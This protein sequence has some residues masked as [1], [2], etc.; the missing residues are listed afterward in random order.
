MPSYS[1]QALDHE[2]DHTNPNHRFAMV[3][4]N[5]VVPT[6]PTRVHKPA[7]GSFDYPALGQ[8]LET[9]DVVTASHDLQSELSEWTELLDPLDQGPKIAAIGPDDLHSAIHIRQRLMRFLAAS[10]SCVA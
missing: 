9:F 10:R 4:A 1:C 2:S 5:L 7:E 3:R 8:D 6:E